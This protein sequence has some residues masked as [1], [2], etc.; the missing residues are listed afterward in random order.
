MTAV[1][2]G[3]TCTRV[4]QQILLLRKPDAYSWASIPGSTGHSV[5]TRRQL[6][7][8]LRREPPPRGFRTGFRRRRRRTPPPPLVRLV[9]RRR[10]KPNRLAMQ[11]AGAVSTPEGESGGDRQ[12]GQMPESTRRRENTSSTEATN[13]QPSPVGT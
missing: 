5:A 10:L 4:P 6:T 12:D 2:P 9:G 1:A 8:A 7:S 13:S 11:F 3:P